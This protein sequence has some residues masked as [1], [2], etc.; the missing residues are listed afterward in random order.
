MTYYLAE[1]EALAKKYSTNN[2]LKIARELD[3]GIDYLPLR[4]ILGI[5][6]TLGK[7]R[8]MVINSNLEEP[9]QIV[10]AAHELAHHVLHPDHN[11]FLILNHTCFGN[12]FEYQA[13]MFTA[14]LLVGKEFN[15]YVEQFRFLAAGRVDMLI[16]I[17][18]SSIKETT[19]E[20]RF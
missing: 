13:N 19:A 12:R 5:A 3:I 17:L 6:Y 4:K 9:E 16:K 14:R 2:P 10:V 11:F 7:K 20:W 1:A 15:K 18:G 8:S